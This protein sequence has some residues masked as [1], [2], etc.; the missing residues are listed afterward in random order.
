[1]A[2]S[3]S[4]EADRF[5]GPRVITLRLRESDGIP[6]NRRLPA[7]I[8]KGALTGDEGADRVRAMLEENGWGGTWTW[9]VYDFH[10]FHDRSHEVLVV[11]RG[12]A[13]LTLG[14]PEGQTLR[15]EAGDV[16]ILPAGTGHCQKDAG[17]G[18]EVCGGYPPGQES[19]AIIRAGD[20]N[21]ADAEHGIVNTPLPETDPIYGR[22]GPLMKAWR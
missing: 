18:F 1:M 5:E 3:Q 16:V 12:W 7:L 21:V 15:V 22:D 17:A 19:P 8:Y 9:H 6:N 10:H 14:G 4:G 2:E 13:D 11:S 20:I